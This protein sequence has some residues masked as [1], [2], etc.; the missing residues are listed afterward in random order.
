MSSMPPGIL[1]AAIALNV[2]SLALVWWG[3]RVATSRRYAREAALLSQELSTN[4]R[5]GEVVVGGAARCWV[6]RGHDRQA[7][8]V[9][10]TTKR[11]LW[12][13]GRDRQELLLDAI[14]DMRDASAPSALIDTPARLVVTAGDHEATFEIVMPKAD[15]ASWIEA[16]SQRLGA[17]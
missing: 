6:Y 17:G 2:V 15:L 14:Q 11:I 3:A 4:P 8:T 9:A 10:L 7:V 1:A 13:H 5:T 12:F 16:A